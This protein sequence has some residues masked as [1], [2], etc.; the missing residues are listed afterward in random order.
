MHQTYWKHKSPTMNWCRQAYF[1][2]SRVLSVISS[3][4]CRIICFH[5]Q[6]VLFRFTP[7][8]I[9]K[10]KTYLTTLMKKSVEILF[11]LIFWALTT[12]VIYLA[13]GKSDYELELINQNGTVTT[14]VRRNIMEAWYF[15]IANVA[16]AGL[17]YLNI[18]VLFPR[19]V[20]SKRFGLY[21]LILLICLILSLVIEQILGNL[22][23]LGREA[24]WVFISPRLPLNATLSLFYLGISFAYCFANSW[25]Q[26]ERQKSDLVKEKLSTELAFLKA[27]VNPHFLF[28]TLNNLYSMANR[29][30]NAELADGIAR[31]SQLMR[32][33]LYES[34]S[35]K[36]LLDKELEYIQSFIEIQ[37]LRLA[38][39]DDF[40]IQF[41][42]EGD[43]HGIRIAPMLLIPFVEN[44]FK[45]GIDFKESS[46]IKI[47]VII[48]NEELVFSVFN[49]CPKTANEMEKGRSGIGLENMKRRLE[50]L[51]YGQYSLELREDQDIHGAIL[52]LRLS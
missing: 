11:H 13:F 31:L 52:K 32:Y 37:K 45:H 33:M 41:S 1:D 26:N 39:E 16:K 14:T 51:Y 22:F 2:R 40:I 38:E 29:P 46:V 34:N 15:G 35:D 10:Q 44:A 17:V 48:E 21:V 6:I 23:F 49:S 50:L 9:K 42:I 8:F 47:E 5:T 20:R 43:T 27:Q 12:W 28:N 24:L 3:E 36:V 4:N 25:A 18:F 7:A 30:E 19:Y